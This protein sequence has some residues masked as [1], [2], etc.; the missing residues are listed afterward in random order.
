MSELGSSVAVGSPDWDERVAFMR[1]QWGR[2]EAIQRLAL[3]TERKHEPRARKA[4]KLLPRERLGRLLDR[5][6]PFLEL[7]PIAGFGMYGDSDGALAGGQL[8][9]GIGFVSGRRCLC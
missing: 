4:G 1:A 3:A 2:V 7:S 6:A 8:I 5:G 9:A